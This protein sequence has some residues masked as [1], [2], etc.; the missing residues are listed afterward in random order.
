MLFSYSALIFYLFS[1][2]SAVQID[3]IKGSTA[4][5]LSKP[6]VSCWNAPPELCC[7]AAGNPENARFSSARLSGL[8]KA[9]QIYSSKDQVCKVQGLNSD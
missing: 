8:K 6:Y 4:C 5:D 7:Y 9:G 3:L 1:T 2:A